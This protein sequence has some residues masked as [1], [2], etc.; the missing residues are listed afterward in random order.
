E[1]LLPVLAARAEVVERTV[2]ELFPR[3]TRRRFSV[4]TGA[5]WAAGRAAADAASLTPGRDA[6]APG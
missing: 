6:L 4:G 5:G 3:V 1:G 2:D